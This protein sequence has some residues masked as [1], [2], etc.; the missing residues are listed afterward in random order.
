MV[1]AH[2]WR[3]IPLHF[4]VLFRDVIILDS[5]FVF[6]AS[7][8]K[9]SLHCWIQRVCDLVWS[10]VCLRVMTRRVRR[11]VET[12]IRTFVRAVRR[13][14]TALSVDNVDKP[15]VDESLQSLEV[16]ARPRL[17]LSDPLLFKAASRRGKTALRLQVSRPWKRSLFFFCQDVFV[18]LRYPPDFFCFAHVSK[19][20]RLLRIP[21]WSVVGNINRLD[22]RRNQRIVMRGR[23][24]CLVRRRRRCRHLLWMLTIRLSSLLMR[25]S[26]LLSR[27]RWERLKL[28]L[29]AR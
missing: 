4:A 9:T 13:Y 28:R 19:N 2:F 18:L 17:C 25:L 21:S 24:L 10:N 5:V 27:R 1:I 12:K 7:W 22:W 14:D 26:R 6:K 23:H 11:L 20:R 15:N 29:E 8:R 3:P 16:F